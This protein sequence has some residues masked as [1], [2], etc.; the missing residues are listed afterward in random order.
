MEN[1]ESWEI[2]NVTLLRACPSYNNL[3][4]K[5]LGNVEVSYVIF[6]HVMEVA[7]SRCVVYILVPTYLLLQSLV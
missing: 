3:C 2:G 5:T 6:T 1:C 4:C 7:F